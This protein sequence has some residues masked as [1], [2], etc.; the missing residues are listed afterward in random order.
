MK[1]FKKLF[2]FL[3]LATALPVLAA[4]KTVTLAVPS[5]DCPMCPV[6]VKKALKAVPG[7]SSVAVS[8]AKKDAVV[9]F[10][11]AKT[12]VPALIKATT[13]AGYPSTLQKSAK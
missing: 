2:A 12:S 10:D 4:T 8:L 9:S 6:T 1:A 7:V 11:D 13:N 3:M 5:M